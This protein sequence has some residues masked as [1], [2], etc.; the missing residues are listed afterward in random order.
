MNSKIYKSREILAYA[1]ICII[2]GTTYFAILT[3]LKEGFQPFIMGSFRFCIAAVLFLMIGLWTKKMDFTPR[4]I[5]Q[6]ML[7]GVVM[8]GG[9]QGLI[10]WAQQ[11]ISSGYAA[12]IEA[13]LPLWFVL[14]DGRNRNQYFK[15]KKIIYG[16]ILG[17]IGIVF[18]FTNEINGFSSGQSLFVIYGILAV[19]A[20]CVCWVGASLYYARHF[21][22]SALISGL[23]WQ[24]LGGMF[25]CIFIAGLSGE[26]TDFNFTIL[27]QKA[28]FSVIYLAL[29]GSVCAFLAYHWLLRQWPSAVVGTYAYI[30]PV[31]A[32]V[33]G[34]F[35]A[36]EKIIGN[37]LVGMGL[38]LVAA[39]IVNRNR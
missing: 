26:F 39:F 18:L 25:C 5:L 28:W 27:N 31:I 4:F 1:A 9:G 3:G 19:I 11:H 12:I 32:V 24:L 21:K 34:Y 23:S 2:W 6:N 35:A 30:N 13:S 38:I 17:F 14:L 7:L 10:F 33:L 8:M 36:S 16:L 15:N 29:A 37:Q 20:S 22:N